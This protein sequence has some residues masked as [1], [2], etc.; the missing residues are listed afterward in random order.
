MVELDDQVARNLQAAAALVDTLTKNPST[1]RDLLGL[2]KKV[3][4]DAYVAELDAQKPLE[5]KIAALEKRIDDQTTAAMTK[6][7]NSQ[8]E[9]ARSRLREQF[10][11]TD[12][13][14]K[15]LEKFMLDT[16]TA[17]HFVA[18]DA[19]QA[20]KPKPSPLRPAFEVRGAIDL[21]DKDD[22]AW[23]QNPERKLDTELNKAFDAIAN[24]MA[25]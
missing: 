4:P 5:D 23:L 25:G 11:Y 13:G 3:K 24:G 21:E 9:S 12:E 8:L 2:I 20:R 17:D 15:T 22:E 7:Q 14:L 1:R 19:M 16:N 10:G 18:H 6:D